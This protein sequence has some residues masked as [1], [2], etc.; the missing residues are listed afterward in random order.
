MGQGAKNQTDSITQKLKCTKTMKIKKTLKI[1]TY[2]IR[3][4]VYHI[5]C[6][7]YKIKSTIVQNSIFLT[8]NLLDS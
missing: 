8:K 7:G 6:G 3:I 2:I 4:T 1:D 5:N